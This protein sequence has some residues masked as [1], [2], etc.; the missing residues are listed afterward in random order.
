[1]AEYPQLIYVGEFPP[2]NHHGGAILLRRL[3]AEHPATRLTVVSS[4]PGITASRAHGLLDCSSL[5]VPP[6]DWPGMPK[7]AAK[8][9]ELAFVL[10]STIVTIKK[11]RAD[12]LITIVQGR[13]YL[14]AAL[15]AWLM[16][17]PH[18]TIVHDNFLS[19]SIGPAGLIRTLKRYLTKQTLIR[20]A[21]IYAVSPEM[22]RLVR[23]ECGV[24]PEI[25]L[26][27]TTAPTRHAD[28][29]AAEVR[30]ERSLN[31][32]FAGL[33]GYTVKD[34][35]DL[36]VELLRSGDLQPG[37]ELHLCCPLAERDLEA[38]GWQHPGVVCR[39]WM[40]PSR[41]AEALAGADVL[42]LPY[43]FREASRAAVETAFPSKTADYLAAGKPL[44]VFGP[45]YSSL[46]HYASEFGFAEIVSE[47]SLEAL[48]RGIRNLASSKDFREELAAKALRV[49]RSNHDMA[50]QR[51]RFYL[52]VSQSLSSTARLTTSAE[53]QRFH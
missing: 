32:L 52:T 50:E 10:I 24:T 35:L 8:V 27:S 12:A 3:L 40:P 37:I 49:F 53:S 33:I 45:P 14:A 36:L 43:S 26:P 39:G 7:S 20:A 47:F 34:C 13:Y 42:F 51:R 5:V 1:M 21:H 30:P 28:S 17:T 9:L 44:L 6:F 25:Q 15:A 2:S 19:E 38:L 16:R 48:A 31:I 11:A 29:A 18:V 46:V 22:Q 41:L 4:R 23:T